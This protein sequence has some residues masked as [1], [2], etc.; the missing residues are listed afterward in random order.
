VVDDGSTDRTP[1]VL[2]GYRD[3]VRVIRQENAGESSARNAGI[4]GARHELIALLDSDNRWLPGKLRRQMELFSGNQTPDFTFTAYTRFG[5]VPRKD[6]VLDGWQATQGHALEQLL[7]GCRINTSTV[8]ATRTSLTTAGL[9]DEALRCAQDY[10]LWLRVAV[11]GYRI[12]YLPQPLTEYRIH[13]E[14]VSGN[15][16]LVSTS[17]EQVLERLFDSGALPGRLQRQRR[18]YLARSYLNSACLYL[19][20]GEGVSAAASIKRAARMRPASIRPGW[21]LIW[22]R[23][24]RIAPARQH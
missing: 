6:I 15:A 7:A 12:A 24:K 21:L 10:D 22:A 23:G 2:A 11:Q 8:V 18:Y 16:A 3:Q 9:F 20:A 4:L 19:G 13:G 5:D 17:T 14:S 1:E